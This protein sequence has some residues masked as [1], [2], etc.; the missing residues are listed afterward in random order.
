MSTYIK[1]GLAQFALDLE[2]MSA[3]YISNL[4]T[5]NRSFGIYHMVAPPPA[6]PGH[7]FNLLNVNKEVSNRRR[8]M[9]TIE[10]LNARNF[11][12]LG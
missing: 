9:Q 7:N 6:I 3:T 11:K 12:F 10:V 8:S 4:Y 1:Y 5:T 2:Y